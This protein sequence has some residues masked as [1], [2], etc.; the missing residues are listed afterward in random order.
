MRWRK[1]AAPTSLPIG[2]TL[3]AKGSGRVDLQAMRANGFAAGIA[4]A[5]IPGV[6]TVQRCI[7]AGQLELR[8]PARFDRHGLALY[9]VYPRQATD[10]GLIELY[11]QRGRCRHRAAGAG[12]AARATGESF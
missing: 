6:N 5:R 10:T 9:C 8:A 3:D 4:L 11:G 12:A 2:R 7:D 1:A